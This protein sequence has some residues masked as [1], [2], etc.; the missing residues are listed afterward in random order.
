MVHLTKG[1]DVMIELHHHQILEIPVLEIVPDVGTDQCLPTV[2]FY[3]GWTGCKDAVVLY[4]VELAKK[5]IRAILPD[6][7][8]HGERNIDQDQEISPALFWDIVIQSMEEFQKLSHFFIEHEKVE[9]HQLGVAGLS[10]GG[11]IASGIYTHY[12]D[13]VSSGVCLMGTPEL[14][15]FA[16]Y[17]VSIA[18][19]KELSIPDLVLERVL[20]ALEPYDLSEHLS[21]LEKRPFHMWH[22]TQDEIVPYGSSSGFYLRIQ[23]EDPIATFTFSS[24]PVGHHVP[25]HV[26][27]EMATFFYQI[28]QL[29]KGY[30]D[31]RTTL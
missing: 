23:E 16:E 31:G 15:K 26:S 21:A 30:Y 13:L 19:G 18:Q 6:C 27:V 2:F 14:M 10:M 20:V 28:L 29:K 24:N 9:Q 22:G 25:Y 11:M 5:G 7:P 12:K 4:G 3:H 1:E 17:T 8:M